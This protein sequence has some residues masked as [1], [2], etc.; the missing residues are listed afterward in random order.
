MKSILPYFLIVLFFCSGCSLFTNKP[1]HE[2]T[3]RELADE[4]MQEFKKKN[5]GASVLLYEKLKDW[6]PFS[7]LAVDAEL[8]IADAH[9]K[10]K[11]F[12]EAVSAYDQFERLHP[13]N[14]HIPY[15]LYQIGCCY[16]EQMDTIDRDQTP[17]RNTL[18]AFSRLINKFPD[19]SFS[20]KSEEYIRICLRNLAEH[21]FYVGLFYYKTKHFKAA[22]YRF[23]SVVSKYPDI[24][25][26]GKALQYIALCEAKI[27]E[28]SD[29]PALNKNTIP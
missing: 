3:A 17:S 15:V 12:Q 27:K 26:H 13:R 21:D 25:V 22:L 28:D 18:K 7:E 1:V 24:G 6:Y 14:E 16:F 9:Y 23:R 4:G 10:L 29:Q 11:E 20:D 5:Y 2:K 8:K 19:S